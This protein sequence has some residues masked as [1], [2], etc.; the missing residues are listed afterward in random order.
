MGD[1]M[2]LASQT[3]GWRASMCAA[4]AIICHYH[5]DLRAEAKPMVE[6]PAGAAEEGVGG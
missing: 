2:S 5:K 6:L 4:E 1:G 3:R